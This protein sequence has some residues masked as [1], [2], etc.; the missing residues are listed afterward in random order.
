MHKQTRPAF[1]LLICL[2]LAT[3]SACGFRLRGFIQLPAS[4]QPLYISSQG[5]AVGLAKRLARQLEQSGVEIT[6]SSEASRLRLEVFDLASSQRQLAFGAT[7]EYELSLQITASAY[8]T[9]LATA[10]SSEQELD[11]KVSNNTNNNE[12]DALFLNQ[13]FTS[14]RFY[15][16]NK[17]T[18][19]LLARDTLKK[20]LLES[21]EADLLSQL[22]LRIQ[23][24]S[25]EENES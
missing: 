15:S 19:S 14:S 6:T 12:S 9:A 13:T 23:T 25:L 3:A 2:V 10:A 1:I 21:M 8:K 5:G 7:E 22:T 24:L 16:Y 4:V 17:N 20:E 18:D 11:E